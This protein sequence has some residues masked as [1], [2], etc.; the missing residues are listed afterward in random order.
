MN[1]KVSQF[2][3]VKN[4]LI[5]TSDNGRYFQSYDSIIAFIPNSG[6]IQL[7]SK[8]WDFS[9]TTGKYRNI[10]LNEDKKTTEAK[11]KAGQ[12]ILKNLN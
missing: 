8:F 4:Q 1:I 7:D 2:G 6:K 10:F 12:Y 3:D 9:P 11:I 5:I